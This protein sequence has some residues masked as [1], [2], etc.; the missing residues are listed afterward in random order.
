MSGKPE[1]RNHQIYTIVNVTKS[2]I[3][4]RV[5]CCKLTNGDFTFEYDFIT[6]TE[7]NQFYRLYVFLH[8]NQRK[9][10]RFT[11]KG[12]FKWKQ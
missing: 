10:Q 3:S 2:D 12:K 7:A 9:L 4:G 11:E 8:P 5:M 6:D 1:I